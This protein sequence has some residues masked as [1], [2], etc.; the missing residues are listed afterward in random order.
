M[1]EHDWNKNPRKKTFWDENLWKQ[2]ILGRE[3]FGIFRKSILW[4]MGHIWN[5]TT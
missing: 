1:N 4:G 2:N 3:Q 5:I